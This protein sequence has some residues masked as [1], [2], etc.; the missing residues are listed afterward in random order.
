MNKTLRVIL[1]LAAIALVGLLLFIFVPVRLTPAVAALPA[2]WEPPEGYGEYV[3]HTGDCKACHTAEGGRPF[4][5]GRPIA[6]PMGTIYSTNITPDPE[7]GIGAYSLD[8]FRG[9]LYDGI[10]NDGVH[11]YPAMPYENYRMLT[12]E[13]VRSLYHYFMNEVEPVSYTPDETALN[14][15][16]NLRWG[17]RAWNWLALQ[18]PAGFT[19]SYDDEVLA[20][21]Q[22]LVEAP[23]HCAAC[24]SP[25]NR[26]VVQDGIVAGQENFLTGGVI[27]GWNAAP[28]N[29]P[30]SAPQRWTVAE[31]AGF[32]A[33]GR[34]HHST[35]NGEMGLV[36]EESTQY[37]TDEDNIA[38]AAFL[39]GLAGGTVELPQ[40]VEGVHSIAIP[41]DPADEAGEATTQ[42]LH[43]AQPG[44]PIGAR[45]YMDNC[46][47]CH[48][49]AGKGAPQIFPKLAGNTLVTGSETMPLISIILDGAAVVSTEK[50][51]MRLV[52]QG[53]RERLNDQEV[54]ELASFVRSAWG[55]DA[56][57]VTAAEV[58]EVRADTAEDVPERA[59]MR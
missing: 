10:R 7:A 58:A 13:D 12:E 28:L 47:A 24:H 57:A 49:V 44:M 39:R 37:L 18:H 51:P 56:S 17:I 45:L 2:D 6:S 25:R 21:G 8:E 46:V 14:F 48:F 31:L 42:M 54:A 22:Y 1:I 35:A 38:I 50:R 23:G 3:M 36:I 52:M 40:P 34:N 30:N 43:D 11:L 41:P 20:R 15:P 5:G 19:P 59:V 26:L 29:G 33:T 53:Y 27:G 55:N 4:A 16:F 9:A 32:L